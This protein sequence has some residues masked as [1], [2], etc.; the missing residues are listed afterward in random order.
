[1]SAV[2][3]AKEAL[4]MWPSCAET[5]RFRMLLLRLDRTAH[6]ME[7]Q[8]FASIRVYGLTSLAR[9]DRSRPLAEVDHL[10]LG[11]SDPSESNKGFSEA[12][13]CP[14]HSVYPAANRARLVNAALGARQL[15]NSG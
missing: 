4:E 14:V 9:D 8:R 2:T 5:R 13:T 7:G 6:F 1:M 10:S 12:Q 3:D 15:C 11:P